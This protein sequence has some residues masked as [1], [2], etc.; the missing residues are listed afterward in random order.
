MDYGNNST[1]NLYLNV[2]SISN[3][4]NMVVKSSLNETFK[5]YGIQHQHWQILKIL[6]FNEA[7]TP[8]QIADLMGITKPLLSR[9]VEHLEIHGLVERKMNNE[10]RRM[11]DLVITDKGKQYAEIGLKAVNKLP[12][13]LED[14]LTEEQLAL[15]SLNENHFVI[16]SI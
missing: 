4:L 9:G 14:S 7:Y 11:V 2:C 10:D 15:S 8:S 16:G 12:Q 6:Y 5:N 3:K 1:L 13:L